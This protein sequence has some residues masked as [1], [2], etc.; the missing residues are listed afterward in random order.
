MRAKLGKPVR[1]LVTID[2]GRDE[3]DKLRITIADDGGGM[4]VESL[5]DV[6]SR[7]GTRST[8]S[9]E[10]SDDEVLAL[11]FESG[12][13]T[14]PIVTDVSGRGIGLAIVREKVEQLGGSVRARSERTRGTTFEL[15]VPAS[16]ASSRGVVAHASEHVYV[17]P[18][19]HVER[20]SRVDIDGIATVEGVET[21]SLEGEAVPFAFLHDALGLPRG[22]RDGDSG[23]LPV[24][25]ISAGGERVAYAVDRIVGEQD[26][27]V[28]SLGPQLE[29]VRHVSGATI[30]ESNQVALILN[31]TDLVRWMTRDAPSRTVASVDAVVEEKQ[32]RKS[33]L[34]VEDSITSRTLLKSILETAGYEVRTAV[35]GL[36]ALDVMTR[37]D[38]D[39]AVLDIE[40]PRMNGL[41]LCAKLRADK[42]HAD[43]P[44]MFVTGRESPEERERGLDVGAN[45]YITKA[46]FDRTTLLET[47][48]RLA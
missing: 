39:L 26:V 2:V 44:V 18:A 7:A 36:D 6:A 9:A 24:I 14:S 11:A 5:R 17:F 20:V 27:L 15:I 23:R 37:H 19:T 45:A 41:D 46:S 42:K 38:F 22:A 34:V 1:G 48:R 47:V 32:Q 25:V 33:I 8:G 29:A 16:V 28:K 31:P 12:V 3:G 4:D 13:S 43:L 35:D 40:M 21:V 10:A 30:L